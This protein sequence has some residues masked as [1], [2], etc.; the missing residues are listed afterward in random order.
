M[1]S[2]SSISRSITSNASSSWHGVSGGSTQT[3]AEVDPGIT[4]DLAKHEGCDME[5]MLR[6][7]VNRCRNPALPPNT[8]PI[9][10]T[11]QLLSTENYP[12]GAPG[13][14]SDRTARPS[15]TTP[16][17]HGSPDPNSQENPSDPA[18]Q[19]SENP[20][21]PPTQPDLLELGLEAAL[22]HCKNAELLKLLDEFKNGKE[23]NR[24]VPLAKA[25]NCA[26]SLSSTMQLPGIRGPSHLQP[27]FVVS[28]PDRF[29]WRSG[30]QRSPDL[31]LLSLSAARQL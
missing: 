8:A 22:G 18:A 17:Y 30:V 28:D 4:V 3:R 26:L 7:L 23:K 10:S 5:T 6:V 24:Y 25:L 19:P 31:A 11:P 2:K 14:S 16:Q 29:Y 15:A 9:P 27:L 21:D 1:Q 12:D 13:A 20:T